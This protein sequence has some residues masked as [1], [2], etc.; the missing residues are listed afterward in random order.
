MSDKISILGIEGFGYHGVFES[1]RREG[2]NFAV[3]VEL[4]ANLQNLEDELSETVDYS[5]IVELVSA[6]ISSNPVNLIET[7]AERIGNRILEF[8]KKIT[9]LGVTVHKPSAPV[10]TKVSDISVTIFKSR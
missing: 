5:K 8:D 10:S 4:F 9:K 2:Q 1:E 3:D 7:L 6:E